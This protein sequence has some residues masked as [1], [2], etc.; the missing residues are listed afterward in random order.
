LLL[1]ELVLKVLVFLAEP[2][3]TVLVFLTKLVLTV[4]IFCTELVLLLKASTGNVGKMVGMQ[5]NEI[6]NAKAEYEAEA[7]RQKEEMEVISSS[8]HIHH[9]APSRH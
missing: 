1:N 7:Q 4:L 9:P 6:G 8:R 2:I 3:F 5:S